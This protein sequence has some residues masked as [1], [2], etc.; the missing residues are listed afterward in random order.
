MVRLH[1]QI[2]EE[3]RKDILAFGRGACGGQVVRGLS[4]QLA[5][6]YESGVSLA[7]ECESQLG[8]QVR[9]KTTIFRQVVGLD[10]PVNSM[11]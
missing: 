1:W 10:G 8:S 11:V 6:D 7:P 5:G 3:V 9:A 4:R 2:G